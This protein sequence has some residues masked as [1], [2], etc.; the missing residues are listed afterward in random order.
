MVQL[1]SVFSLQGTTVI[2]VET[3][4]PA[5]VLTEPTGSLYSW[6][7]ITW[8]HF[9]GCLFNLLFVCSLEK[10]L[11]CNSGWPQT[12]KSP[13]SIEYCWDY[14]SMSQC[15][16]LK[17][18]FLVFFLNKYIF[19][20]FCLGKRMWLGKGSSL[21]GSQKCRVLCFYLFYLQCGFKVVLG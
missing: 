7:L 20:K 4:H 10:V 18:R 3:A 12:L 6:V 11:L 17:N 14:R 15:Q 21:G 13:A 16:T 1:F 9:G 8:M 19:M 2:K 5:R